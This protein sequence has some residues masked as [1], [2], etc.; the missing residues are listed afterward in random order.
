VLC[1]DEVH[2]IEEELKQMSPNMKASNEYDRLDREQKELQLQLQQ[3]KRR[4]DEAEK[5][6]NDVKEQRKARFMDA[7]NHMS[8]HID[9]IY[10]QMTRGRDTPE[11]GVAHM[12]LETSREPYTAGVRFSAMPPNKR[13]MEMDQLSGGEKSVAAL[14]LLFTVHSYRPSPFFV[15][16]EIDAALDATNIGKVA[17]FIRHRSAAEDKETGRRFQCIV[18]SLKEAFYHKADGLV[19]VMKDPREVCSKSLTL[20]LTQFDERRDEPEQ[21]QSTGTNADAGMHGED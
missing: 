8:S 6:F 2:Q 17:N 12:H 3:Q 16:D 10:K 11:G 4:H 1:R 7:F 20:D 13:Y 5:H 19:G 15:L 14:A 9:S 18:I 21:A